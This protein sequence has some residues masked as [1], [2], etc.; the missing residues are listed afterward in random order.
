MRHRLFAA[1]RPP[2][3][4]IEAPLDLGSEMAG[5]RSCSRPPPATTRPDHPRRGLTG[6]R[7]FAER[8][9]RQ[10]LLPTVTPAKVD[11]LE[12]WPFGLL[13]SNLNAAPNSAA[14]GP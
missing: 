4:V 5:A 9:R 14:L 2:A 6:G 10:F 8:H 3:E 1:I 13:M 11:E 7:D 12:D